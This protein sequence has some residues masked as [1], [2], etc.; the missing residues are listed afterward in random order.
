KNIRMGTVCKYRNHSTCVIVSG[1]ISFDKRCCNISLW[2]T[3]T[4]GFMISSNDN[5]S[6]FIGV[7]KV[8]S[9][10]DCFIKID[11]FSNNH[12]SIVGVSAPIY[13][14][15]FDHEKEGLFLVV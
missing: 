15:S 9:F 6:V 11:P 14:S 2:N 3:K 1:E 8:D 13:L 12:S 7:G 4:R 5:Q 10:G